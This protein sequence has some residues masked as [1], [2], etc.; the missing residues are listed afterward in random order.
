MTPSDIRQRLH[1]DGCSLRFIMSHLGITRAEAHM[2]CDHC[3][4]RRDKSGT[5]YRVPSL[6]RTKEAEKAMGRV[7]TVQT[8][9]GR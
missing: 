7:T 6:A 9:D 8:G 4:A 5:K 3:G 2:L 1:G